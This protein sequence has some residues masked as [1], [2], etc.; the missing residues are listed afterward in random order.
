MLDSK[1]V[2]VEGFY[3]VVILLQW[4][5]LFK[6]FKRKDVNYFTRVFSIIVSIVISLIILLAFLSGADNDI[7]GSGGWNKLLYFFIGIVVLAVEIIT[8]II[9]LILQR[10]VK[11]KLKI[12]NEEE[13]AQNRKG[14]FILGIILLLVYIIILFVP[15][16]IE[17]QKIK[18]AEVDVKEY[19]EKYLIENY[20]GEEFRIVSIERDY[21]YNG[22]ILSYFVGFEARI[23][24]QNTSEKF[25]VDIHRFK[26][27]RF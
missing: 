8:C 6:A 7:I 18:R 16:Q 25:V 11:K 4:I 12:Q 19:I 21:T 3:F 26:E 20:E 15:Y 23:I 14:S 10:I 2:L 1:F 13:L 5:I 9:A 22:I 17:V 24:S 27:R